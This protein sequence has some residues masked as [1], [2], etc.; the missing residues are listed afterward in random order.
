MKFC[1]LMGS[2]RKS[3][4]TNKLLKILIDELKVSQNNIDIIWLYDKNINPCKACRKCQDVL[5]GYGCGIKDD[6]EEIFQQIL[7]ADCLLLATPIY[8]WY[9]TAPMKLVL[10]RMAYGF[11]KYFGKIR[12]EP[13]LAG[14]KCAILATCGYKV[15]KGSDLFERGIKRFCT[16][17]VM[18][19]IGSLTVQDP[20][21]NL[22]FLDD[23]KIEVT[24]NFAYKLNSYNM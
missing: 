17:S 7:D 10:D 11:N 15:S 21:Y 12:G 3:G 6:M 8:T 22:E 1:I 2:P 5:D 9:C 16:H 24:K 4:N 19:Y 14:K 20:G 18:Q 23:E 13:L